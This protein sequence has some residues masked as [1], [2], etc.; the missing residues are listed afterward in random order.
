[1]ESTVT[2]TEAV[3][4]ISALIDR[5]VG[6]GE[7]RGCRHR[8][9][10]IPAE[11]ECDLGLHARLAE[12]GERMSERLDTRVKVQVGRSKGKV[13]IEFATLDDLQRIV[14]IVAPPARGVFG[15]PLS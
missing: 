6:R 5:V 9:L 14:D 2:V 11:E 1:M 7:D 15:E 12:L 4:G 8:S 10:E 13:V 3:Q